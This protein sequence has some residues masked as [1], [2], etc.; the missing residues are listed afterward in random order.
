V[1]DRARPAR[2]DSAKRGRDYRN[3]AKEQQAKSAERAL[4]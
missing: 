3:A 1:R 2:T 4:R